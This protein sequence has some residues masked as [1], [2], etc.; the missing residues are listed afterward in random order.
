VVGGGAAGM[1]AAIAAAREGCQVVLLER[2]D[3]VGK[4]ILATGNG[5]CN[6]SNRDMGIVHYYGEDLSTAENILNTFG[7][8]EAEDFFA[9]LGMLIREKNGYL[10]PAS[11][12][13]STVLDLLRLELDKLGVE[14]KTHQKVLKISGGKSR[15][16][17]LTVH[18]QNDHFSCHSVILACGGCAAPGTGSDGNG[19]T[20]AKQLGHSIVP[21][22][23]ALVQLRC[24]QKDFKAI[25]GV[26]AKACVTLLIDG[27]V[28]AQEQGELQLTDVGVSGIVVFQLS[29]MAAYGLKNKKAVAVKIDLM[30]EYSEEQFRQ[31]MQKRLQDFFHRT[32]EEFLLGMIHKKLALYFMKQ[33]N[34]KSNQ[35]VSQ[36]EKKSLEKLLLLCKQWHLSVEAAGSFEN[37]QVTAGGV[38]FSEVTRELE[39]RKMPGVYFAGEILD[40]DGKCG[41]YNL[42]WAW[43]S[44]YMAGKN[45][46]KGKKA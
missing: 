46:A 38:P 3:R 24:K 42:Q 22:V 31:L 29:R 10:Y 13:A 44:G 20:L 14:V 34:L 8:E 30:P 26:R 18:T 21:T 6:F 15:E 32:L 9:S 37:A 19:Y 11:E 43:S 39:S 17:A 1:T 27:Q 25:S 35:R 28:V 45:V 5:K 33:I 41:G 12:Q 2:N 40:I 16:Q 7:V 23:P 4:K 36:T